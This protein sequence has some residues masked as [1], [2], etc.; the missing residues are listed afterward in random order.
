MK[1]YTLPRTISLFHKGGIDSK[2]YQYALH[3]LQRL[4]HRIGVSAEPREYKGKSASFFLALG[5]E[6]KASGSSVNLKHDSFR[7]S[8][9]EAGIELSADSAKGVLN[10]VYHLAEQLGYLFLLPG[11]SGEWAPEKVSDLPFGKKIVQPR[12]PFR[13]VFWGDS[14]VKDYTVEEWLR[15]YA[16]LK[17]NALFNN[18]EDLP[19]AEELGIRIEVGGMAFPKCFPG[20]CLPTSLKCSACSNRKISTDEDLMIPIYVSLIRKP[21]KS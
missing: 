20:N 11:E 2:C 16:K 19:L 12:F 9:S 17:F 1:T 13:G 10:G 15:F 7:I 4:L 6:C 21:G 18:I 3:E 14:S 8:V 5:D